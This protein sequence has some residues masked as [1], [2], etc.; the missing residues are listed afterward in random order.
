M[1]SASVEVIYQSVESLI[2]D[3]DAF[4]NNST[5]VR[6]IDMGPLPIAVMSVTVGMIILIFSSFYKYYFF[7]YFSLQSCFSISLFSN[8]QSNNVC[9]CSRSFK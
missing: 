8:S 4:K 2:S 3:I 7:C 6:Q 5:D 1:V 9:C